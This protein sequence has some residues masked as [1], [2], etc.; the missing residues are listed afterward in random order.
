M[1]RI[2]I[3]EFRISP[4][5]FYLLSGFRFRPASGSEFI[6]WGWT[7]RNTLSA[8]FDSDSRPNWACCDARFQGRFREP[9]PF[10][11]KRGVTKIGHH[12]DE[13]KIRNPKFEIRNKSKIK[14]GNVQNI[15]LY[16]TIKIS[17]RPKSDFNSISTGST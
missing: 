10:D 13:D 17:Q 7:S 6:V 5:G 8:G 1:F 2:S 15:T 4:K 9:P 16:K 11:Q 14:M 3:F 12:T